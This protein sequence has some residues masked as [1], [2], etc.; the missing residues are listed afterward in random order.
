MIVWYPRVAADTRFVDSPKRRGSFSSRWSRALLSPACQLSQVY[1]FR[2]PGRRKGRLE[3]CGWRVLLVLDSDSPPLSCFRSFPW[4]PSPSPPPPPPRFAPPPPAPS[5]LTNT[6][7][8]T[9]SCLRTQN[10]RYA[11]FS[12]SISFPLAWSSRICAFFMKWDIH[13]FELTLLHSTHPRQLLVTFGL[14]FLSQK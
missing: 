1:V 9:P 6:R 3:A 11:R 2:G 13:V 4:L 7:S 12:S 5:R 14:R 10:S 8:E